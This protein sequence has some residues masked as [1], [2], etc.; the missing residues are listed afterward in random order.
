M[1]KVAKLALMEAAEGDARKAVALEL[2]EDGVLTSG[3]ERRAL[4]VLEEDDEFEAGHD[5]EDD[6][7]YYD[8]VDYEG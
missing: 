2:L 3:E 7:A 1:D 6:V 5:Y 8:A 4:A